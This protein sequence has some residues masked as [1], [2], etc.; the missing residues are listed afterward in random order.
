MLIGSLGAKGDERVRQTC[1][2][3]DPGRPFTL[4][5]RLVHRE[6]FEALFVVMMYANDCRINN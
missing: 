1:I 6:N 2:P 4:H 5:G 3:V